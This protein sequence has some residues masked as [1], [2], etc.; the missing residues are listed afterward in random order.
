MTLRLTRL[1]S[2]VPIVDGQ[3][4]PTLQFQLL[5][6]RNLEAIEGA[7]SGLAEQ[8]EAIQA[9]Q[10]SADAAARELARINSYTVPTVAL[11]AADAGSDATI[12]VANHTRVYPVQ[13]TVDV[14]D[15][16]IT[17]ASLTG[18]SFSTDYYVYYDD[19]TLED[20]TP[21]FLTTTSIETAQVGAAA[22]RHFVG[23][24]TTPVDGGGA[25]GGTGGFPPGGG[26]GTPIP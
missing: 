8:L 10:A 1:E 21:T 3:G 19:A 12:T 18:L 20:E 6:Q 9:A 5:Y 24:V 11:S 14:P 22:G 13:G 16:A 17:G 26:G 23:K 7:V 2:T 15:V 4:R 25:T